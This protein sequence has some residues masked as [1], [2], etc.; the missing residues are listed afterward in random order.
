MPPCLTKLGLWKRH[1]ERVCEVL[2]HALIL[3][4]KKTDL[5][6]DEDKLNRQLHFCLQE[7]NKYLYAQG[8]GLDNP[9]YSEARNQPSS[10]HDEKHERED[11]RPD[12]QN[13]FVDHSEPNPFKQN[14]SFCIECKRLGDPTSPSWILNNNYVNNGI[15]R[16][17]K[18]QH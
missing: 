14:K 15:A 1:E 7:A 3:L 10:Y 11:K 9:F 2:A 5:I 17:I 13:S 4:Q 16:F 18:E 6:Q 12:L 8:R